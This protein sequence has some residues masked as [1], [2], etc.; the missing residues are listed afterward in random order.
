MVLDHASSMSLSPAW[1]IASLGAG[2]TSIVLEMESWKYKEVHLSEYGV[3][4]NARIL[5]R[6]YTGQTGNMTAVEWHANSPPLRFPG[7]ILRLIGVP[8]GDQSIPQIGKVCI[9]VTWIRA[10]ES[11]EWSYLVTAFEAAGARDYA[12]ALVFAQSAVE[13]TMMPLIESRLSLHASKERVKNLVRGESSYGH[14]LNVILPYICG[15]LKLPK[16]PE[17]LRGSLNKMR[18]IRNDIIHDGKKSTDLTAAD[19]ME[20]LCASAFGFE[21]V[22]FIRPEIEKA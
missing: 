13:V 10:E 15:E 9:S 12:P 2:R 7:T 3:P 8:F 5:S 1:A 20:G 14:A 17:A 11:E 22:R 19:A 18:R 16:M 21:Y 6:N 4:P